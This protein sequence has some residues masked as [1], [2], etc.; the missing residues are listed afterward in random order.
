[1]DHVDHVAIGVADFDERL[2]TLSSTIGLPVRRRGTYF[3][4]GRRLAMLGGPSGGFK[5][6]LCESPEQTGF[7]HIAFRVDDVRAEF[8]RLVAAG[9]TP[10]G[11]PRRIEPARA[12]SAM[13]EDSD[14]WRIQ[15]IRYDADSPDL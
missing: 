11:E 7:L 10:I 5:I 15:V 9:M 12:E 8:D 1:M 4:N 3:L 13:V 14:G 2:D 6:E